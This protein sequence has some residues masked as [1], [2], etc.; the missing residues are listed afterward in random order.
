MASASTEGPP[1]PALFLV[2]GQGSGRGGEKGMEMRSW[3]GVSSRA[4]LSYLWLW[5]QV[6]RENLWERKETLAWW[7]K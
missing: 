6:P 5:E 1:G 7:T 2:Q 4:L 3:T